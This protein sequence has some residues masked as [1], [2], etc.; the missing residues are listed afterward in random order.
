[1]VTSGILHD[2]KATTEGKQE[3]AAPVKSD[4]IGVSRI[5]R[6]HE[7]HC[8]ITIGYRDSCVANIL[9]SI[10]GRHCTCCCK[11]EGRLL[12]IKKEINDIEDIIR[13][14]CMVYLS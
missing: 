13:L 14:L 10:N 7:L 12:K 2:V 11:P 8:H 6:P 1:M 9:T 4:V 3:E 5:A